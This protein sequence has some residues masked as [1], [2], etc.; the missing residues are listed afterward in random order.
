MAVFG[1]L[2][3]KGKFVTIYDPSNQPSDIS[4][5]I[6]HYTVRPYIVDSREPDTI[7]T[8]RLY[9]R[10]PHTSPFSST[11]LSIGLLA[12]NPYSPTTPL[13]ND[14][15]NANHTHI[16]DTHLVSMSATQLR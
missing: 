7:H 2:S 10:L 3:S 6:F 13:L 12:P 8:F 16:F 9:L 11:I 1:F 5:F 15:S 14:T 4:Y